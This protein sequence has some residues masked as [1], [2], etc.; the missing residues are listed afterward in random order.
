MMFV[1]VSC[2]R[3]SGIR[4]APHRYEDDRYHVSLTK[5]GPH[6]PLFDARDIPVTWKM[7]IHS[8]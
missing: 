5:E 8:G 4:L 6:I 2:G 7:D 3:N 1:I